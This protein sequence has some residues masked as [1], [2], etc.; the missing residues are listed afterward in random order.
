MNHII[1][2][3]GYLAH[4]VTMFKEHFV[5]KFLFAL[6]I[7]IITFFFD[8]N[9]AQ[10]IYALIVLMTLDMITGT[11]VAIKQG[12]FKSRKSFYTPVKFFVYLA[13]VSASYQLEI[14]LGGYSVLFVD[15]IM[16][17]FLALTEFFS[18]ME[19]A[20]NLG[21]KTPHKLLGNLKNI[22]DKM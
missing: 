16:I 18:L 6:S 13:L 22:K 19:N 8:V 2:T 20:G 5:L 7:P 10:L 21:Y 17:G 12:N 14:A 3:T 11:M 9:N 1:H 15:E 4:L